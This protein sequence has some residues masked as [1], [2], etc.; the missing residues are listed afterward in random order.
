M[1]IDHAEEYATQH[2]MTIARGSASRTIPAYDR[3][4]RWDSEQLKIKGSRWTSVL[5]PVWL[6]GFVEN[7][8]G[9]AVTHYM[10]VNGRTGAT[11]GSVP[12]NSAKANAVSWAVAVGI[13]IITW[14]I[15][16]IV[17]AA[18]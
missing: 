9:K 11:M 3:G 17:L 7:K 12:I 16:I 6:Y 15:A 2:F 10:A 14:P 1:D 4:V 8:N 13:S 5:L 18:S